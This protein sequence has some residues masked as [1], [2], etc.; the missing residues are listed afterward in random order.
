MKS[1]YL[2]GIL[3][4][5]TLTL[6]ATAASAS[7][8]V[9]VWIKVKQV[10]LEPNAKAPTRVKVHGAAMLYDKST[11]TSYTGY[12]EPALGFLYYEC[13]KG[14]EAT[15]VSEWADLTKNIKDTD[16]ICVGFGS[17]TQSPG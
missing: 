12:T 17:Q 10:D 1:R 16:D 15:C 7:Y 2:V 3:S 8:P 14:Q 11:G 4:A 6:G 5:L 9:G 13:P